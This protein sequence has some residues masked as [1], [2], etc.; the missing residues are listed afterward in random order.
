MTK[1]TPLAPPRDC[2]G[3]PARRSGACAELSPRAQARLGALA[4]PR[5]YPR[6]HRFWREDSAPAFYAVVTRGFLRI[7]RH[8]PDGRRQIVGIAHP[9]EL[10]GAGIESRAGYALEAATPVALCRFDRGAFDRLARALP[11]LRKL[12]TRQ[13][14]RQLHEIRSMSWMLARLSREERL[15]LCLNDMRDLMPWQPQPD[16]SGILTV[17]WSRADIADLLGTTPE[18]ICRVL[19]QL[20]KRGLLRLLDP[21]HIRIDDTAA[22]TD[23]LPLG[24]G[25]ALLRPAESGAPPSVSSLRSADRPGSPHRLDGDQCQQALPAPRSQ[26]ER[27]VPEGR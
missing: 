11:D 18:S 12:I 27:E 8:S 13:V 1:L 4:R 16:R 9:G 25:I 14:L 3:C 19:R 10:I 22:L 23:G 17:E 7:Q 5:N 24:P 26:R 15:R 2:I 6:N 21:Y 20:E